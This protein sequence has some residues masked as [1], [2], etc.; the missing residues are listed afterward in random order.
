MKKIFFSIAAITLLSTAGFATKHKAAKK[1]QA[2]K[3]ECVCPA[4][5][6]KTPDCPKVC[7]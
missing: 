3:T 2:V 6:P 1:K 5:C 4:G 7:S